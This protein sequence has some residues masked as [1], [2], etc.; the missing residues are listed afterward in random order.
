MNRARLLDRVFDFDLE[1]CP[2][3]GGELKIIAVILEQPMIE[4]I[5]THLA[6]QAKMRHA[7]LCVARPERG[8]QR[9]CRD[10]PGAR[11]GR[12]T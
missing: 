5:L 10:R 6:L 11:G 12:V 9:E 3:C 4:K 2:N 1:H 7:H 8:R